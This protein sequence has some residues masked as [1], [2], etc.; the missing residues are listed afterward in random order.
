M[1]GSWDLP[2]LRGTIKLGVQYLS[3]NARNQRLRPILSAGS[4]TVCEPQLYPMF[5]RQILPLHP[6]RRRPR[7]CRLRR[8]IYRHLPMRA[9]EGLDHRDPPLV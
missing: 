6:A 7:F 8:F 9:R 5:R 4:N 2:S 1:D 3:T